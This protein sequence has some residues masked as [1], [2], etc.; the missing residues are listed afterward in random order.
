NAL[1][2]FGVLIFGRYTLSAHRRVRSQLLLWVIRDRVEPATSPA[3]SAMPRWRPEFAAHGNVAMG[4][5]ETYAPQQNSISIRSLRRRGRATSPGYRCRVS[6]RSSV[7]LAVACSTTVNFPLGR[8][9]RF[10][11]TSSVWSNAG[12]PRTSSPSWHLPILQL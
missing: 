4:Q 2:S 10:G 11:S 1:S 3:M 5:Q 6:W 7:E 12:K 8:I 9:A